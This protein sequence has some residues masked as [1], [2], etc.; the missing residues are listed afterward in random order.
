MSIFQRALPGKKAK[1]TAIAAVGVIGVTLGAWALSRG[2]V[3]IPTAVVERGEFSDAMPFHGE[4]QALKSVTI[5]APSDAGDLQIVKIAPNG[6]AVK[7]GDIVVQFDATKTQQDLAQFKSALNSSDAEI[8]QAQA[9]ARL[10]EEADQTAVMKAHFDVE[11]AKLDASKN[12]ILAEIDGAEKKLLVADAEQ[13][14]LQAEEQLKSDRADNAAKIADAE[15]KRKQ[16]QYNVQR[17]ERGL[18]ELTLQAPSA[19]IVAL[20]QVWHPGLGMSVLKAGE[21]AWPG[22]AIAELPDL[23][24]LHLSMRVDESERG[25]LQPGQRITAHF[26]GL[27]ER[28][29]TGQLKQI[30]TIATQDF[31]GGWPFPRNFNVEIGLDQTDARLRPGM[32]SSVR[33]TVDR[34]PNAIMI[35]AQASFQKSGRTVVYVLNGAKFDERRIDI[36]R[37]SGDRLLIAKGLQPGEKVALQDPSLK[38]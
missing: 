15:Q 27:P 8:A 36:G 28:D 6:V 26:D 33:V 23:S 18:A 29:F 25:R 13:R 9:Q 4:V 12:E 37:R 31:T 17:S 11:S 20:L 5:A 16:N 14:L 34:V 24:T 22:A 21:Q 1:L 30:S 19:G 3:S 35:P 2:S 7:Q 10:K 32:S 38:E